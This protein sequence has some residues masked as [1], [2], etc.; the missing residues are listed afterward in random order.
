MSTNS[1]SNKDSSHHHRG[2]VGGEGGS[3]APPASSSDDSDGDSDEETATKELTSWRSAVTAAKS[4]SQLSLYIAQLN[5]S[6]AWEK[7]IMKVVSLSFLV[8]FF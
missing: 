2:G 5:R 4:A 8:F 7:S 6:I 1:S 3:S